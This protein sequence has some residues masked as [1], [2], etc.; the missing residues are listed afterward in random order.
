M[1]FLSEPSFADNQ[2]LD[3]HIRTTLRDD[4]SYIEAAAIRIGTDILEVTGWGDYMINGVDS[5]EFPQ[6]IGGFP[7][8]YRM[9]NKKKHHFEIHYAEQRS[10]Q[11]HTIK[12]L[13][14]IQMKNASMTDFAGSVGLM[15]DFESGRKLGRDAKTDYGLDLNGFGQ[16]WQVKATEARLFDAP[17]FPQSPETCVLPGP[18]KEMSRRLGSS[19]ALEAAQQACSHWD[20]AAQDLCVSDVIAMGDLEAAQ[21]GVF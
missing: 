13:V 8:S 11:V 1:V 5:A 17:R 10:I 14:T 3:I 20:P 7:V 19:V 6:T 12:D 21:A 9:E 16:E 2:G 15:A 4:F 18:R